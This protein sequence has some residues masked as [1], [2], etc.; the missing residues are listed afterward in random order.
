MHPNPRRIIPVF[1]VVILAI[2]AWWYF[3]KQQ[4]QAQAG[5]L[6]ASGTIEATQVQV[7]PEL[8][9]NVSAVLVS[10]GQNIRQGDLIVQLDES[11]LMAQLVQAEA[12]LAVAQAN[13]DLV[14]SGPTLEQR[15]QAITAAQLEVTTAQQAFENLT[16]QAD[17]AA[18][19][20][21]KAVAD[22]DKARDLAQQTVDNMLS[23]ADP[24]DI[25]AAHAAMILAEDRLDKVRDK[26]EPFEKRSEDNVM[27]AALQAQLA[28]AQRDYDNTVTR[29]NN[30]I[31]TSNQYDLAV[32]QANLV[33]FEQQLAEAER[34]YQDLENGPDPD[35]LQL[36][37]QRVA[38]TQALLAAAQADP[39]PEQIAV[40]QAQVDSAQAAIEVIRSQLD[41]LKIHAPMDGIVL[42]RSIEPGEVAQP[43]TPLVTL[44]RL[45]HLTITIYLPED[46]YGEIELDQ[47][48]QVQVDSFPGVQ[49]SAR[50]IH[51]ADQAEYTPRNVQTAEGR[52]TTVFAVKLSIENPDGKLKPG[53]PADVSF[54]S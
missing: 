13:Y 6:A 9:G 48:A 12:A 17:L 40:A 1:L 31:G 38:A 4:I 23:S 25:D 42:G 35:Q 26:F 18:A 51:I 47:T 10:E 24:V 43:G 44:A 8:G 5:G 30:I 37:Q 33:W 19:Q 21:Q 15:Q 52:R 46:R 11:L 54:G 45:D 36:A 27:R 29:Y 2:A 49:F 34:D 32:A 22:A 20:A 53:M 3:D 7:A 41:K 50:V 28:G 16:D 14:V 39:S